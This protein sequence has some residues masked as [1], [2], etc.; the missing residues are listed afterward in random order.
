LYGKPDR[1]QSLQV[2]INRPEK[3]TAPAGSVLT[4]K[5]SSH[6]YTHSRHLTDTLSAL[7]HKRPGWRSSTGS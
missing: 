6:S 3:A 1:Q 7:L 5:P 2:T 4:E